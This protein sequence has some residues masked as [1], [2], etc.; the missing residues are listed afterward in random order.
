MHDPINCITFVII[1]LIKKQRRSV[2][3]CLLVEVRLYFSERTSWECHKG[4]FY[5]G[6]MGTRETLTNTEIQF[7]VIYILEKTAKFSSIGA[8]YLNG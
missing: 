7:G 3:L 6:T 5:L 8:C 1:V 2:C 4:I